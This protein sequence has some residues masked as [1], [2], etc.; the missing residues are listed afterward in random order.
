VTRAGRPAVGLLQIKLAL[1]LTLP[2]LPALAWACGATRPS[3]YVLTGS[4]AGAAIARNGAVLLTGRGFNPD[5]AR[6]VGNAG[7]MRSY[8]LATVTDEHGQHVPGHVEPWFDPQV[9]T[10]AW[11]PLAPLPANSGFTMM[12]LLIQPGVAPPSAAAGTSLQVTF[13]SSDQLAP[14]L[15]LHGELVATLET[16]DLPLAHCNDCGTGCQPYATVRALRA[17]IS[18][19][20][21]E[22][23]V[24][25]DHYAGQLLVAP[26][27]PVDLATRGWGTDVERLPP[28]TA[29]EVLRPL[30][31]GD[32]PYAPCFSL[33]VGDPAGH[34]TNA[35]P[36]CLP[37]L[38]VNAT[39]E[40]LDGK[41][42]VT[43]P[44]PVAKSPTPVEGCAFAGG[45]GGRTTWAWSAFVLALLTT[46]RLAKRRRAPAPSPTSK[47]G[48][49]FTTVPDDVPWMKD[50]V[51]K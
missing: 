9:P 29:I 50:L 15:R 45:A 46:R 17:R 1:S 42:P 24:P 41:P 4:R 16:Y 30:P 44:A 20:A 5:D 33:R 49:R 31:S 39:I 3:T 26:N 40:R 51:V 14:P 28:G 6:D 43:T 2:C 23:G 18:V 10:V 8:L 36:L 25:T 37:T 35:T 22:G 19:P 21:V 13:R 11:Q 34:T 27:Q 38:D 48:R 32:A 47:V 12:A 7:I